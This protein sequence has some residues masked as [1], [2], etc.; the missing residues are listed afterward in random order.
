MPG[1]KRTS[2]QS[3]HV[4]GA[5]RKTSEQER[6]GA[7]RDFRKREERER[8]AEREIGE[9]ERNGEQTISSHKFP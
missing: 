9:R 3:E 7:E 8:I 2:L 4:S 1:N 6:S 5:S